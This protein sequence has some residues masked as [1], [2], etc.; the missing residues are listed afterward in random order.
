MKIVNRGEYIDDLFLHKIIRI[1]W[2]F[3]LLL[4][5]YLYRYELMMEC[6]IENPS[7]RPSF[8]DIVKIVNNYLNGE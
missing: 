2:N 5:D 7:L 3:F 1:L 6:W 4:F 8:G